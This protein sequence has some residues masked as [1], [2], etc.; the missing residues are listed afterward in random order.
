MILRNLRYPQ[1]SG[2]FHLVACHYNFQE[3][4]RKEGRK[5]GMTGRIG[6]DH[7]NTVVHAACFVTC[8]GTE[9]TMLDSLYYQ[10]NTQLTSLGPLVL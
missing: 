3:R 9:A 2:V 10:M 6:C 4:V 7:L 8:V 5:F 1:G